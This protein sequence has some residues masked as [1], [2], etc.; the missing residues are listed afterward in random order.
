MDELGFLDTFFAKKI[1]KE[2]KSEEKQ[3]MLACL[4]REFRKGHLC[5]VLDK[6][7]QLILGEDLF[8][9][10]SALVKEEDRIYLNR[11]YRLET[12][13]LETIL[14]KRSKKFEKKTIDTP[15]LL[16]E[17]KKAS[18]SVIENSLTIISG[19]P[20][21]GKTFTAAQIVKVLNPKKVILTAPTGKAA[22]HL[23]TTLLEKI[24]SS[25][26]EIK[27]STLHRLLN[28][29]PDDSSLEDI[30]T[31][32][33]D[34]VIVDEASMIDITLFAQVLKAVDDNTR[35]VF[36]GDPD[37][38]P[39]VDAP[40][41]FREISEL[42]AIQLTQVMRTDREDLK[43]TANLVKNG[44]IPN[45]TEKFID[46]SRL[47]QVV[48][49]CIFNEPPNPIDVVKS[50]EKVKIINALRQGLQGSDHM[51]QLILKEL[52][53]KI[54][55]G[56]FWAVPIL[57][58]KN[59]PSLDLYNGCSGVIIGQHAKGA[60]RLQNGKIF[61]Q[62]KWIES[63]VAFEL[64]FVLS[65]HKSQGSEF[66]EVIALFPQGSENF[67]KE[68]L[69]TA[70][71]RAKKTI[72]IFGEEKILRKMLEVQSRRMSGFTQRYQLLSA[73]SS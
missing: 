39:P 13:I 24:G 50:F 57:I 37:Q 53:S 22:I 46:E 54:R 14:R 11:T 66:D 41:L 26:I 60:F 19:G 40:T 49:L 67:G 68:A 6:K 45:F 4:M 72:E 69:Y 63:T 9:L 51:N 5:V 32:D 16:A 43:K 35:L 21:T 61:I 27:A 52:K 47:L 71:T 17:Q 59:I 15:L 7:Q 8:G 65:I 23:Q 62:G 25:D 20:G 34:L 38:L 29:D 56:Q 33:A 3:Q 73:T 44:S 10:D 48:N 31:L 58:T 36:M 2:D 28:I 30:Q 70:V 64:G 42:F 1:L 12:F 18:E 55:Y